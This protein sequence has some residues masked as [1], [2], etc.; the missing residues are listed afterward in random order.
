MAARRLG[1][2]WLAIMAV[3]MAASPRAADGIPYFARRYGVQCR[4]CHVVPP[5]LN[6]FGE[7]FVARGYQMPALTPRRTWPLTVWLSGRAEDLPNVENVGSY[8]NRIELISGGR[9]VAPWLWYFA[10]WRALSFEARADGSLRDR[11][12][13]FEDLFVTASWRNAELTL[14]QFR[15]VGQVDVSRRQGLSEPLV[16]S[17]ALPGTGGGTARE[18]S[19]RGFAPAGRSPGPRLAWNQPLAREWRWTTSATLPLPGELS[20]PLTREARTEASAEL[21]WKPKGILLESFVRGGLTSF[22]AHAFYDAG[23]RR[24][25][26]VVATGNRGATHWTVMTGLARSGGVSR[27]RW[28]LEGEYSPWRPVAVGGRVEDEAGDGRGRA[29]VAY[30]N[31]H[32]PGTRYTVRLTVELRIQKERNATIVELGTVF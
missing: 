17:A 5:K 3:G 15:T 20:L 16:L 27:G 9:L 11:S 18:V 4:Q 23:G 14:G 2:P 29:L 25:L 7:A 32:S 28:S 21:E 19:L 24:L 1:V 6:A 30:V 12:G 10:E 22:G 26:N 31:A 8:L 13:R